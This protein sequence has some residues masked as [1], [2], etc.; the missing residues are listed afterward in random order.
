M[1]QNRETKFG[2]W[3][4]CSP[5]QNIKEADLKAVEGGPG[6]AVVLGEADHHDLRAVPDQAPEPRV[7]GALD[8]RVV[9][10]GGVRV[11][12]GVGALLDHLRLLWSG[13]TRMEIS[14]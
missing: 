3:H 4:Y 1:S 10:E 11:N 6:D 2:C 7:P 12:Q 14:A 8:V 13:Q 5:S 9:E